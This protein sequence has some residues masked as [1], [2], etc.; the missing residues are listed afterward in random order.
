M[1][2][3]QWVATFK[4]HF[5]DRGFVGDKNGV[6][7][8]MERIVCLRVMFILMYGTVWKTRRQLKKRGEKKAKDAAKDASQIASV[9]SFS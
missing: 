3:E 5:T 8:V 7:P 2:R 9:E 6:C 4:G 1:R